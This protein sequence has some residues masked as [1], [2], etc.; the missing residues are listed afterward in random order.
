M[1]FPGKT[2]G[3]ISFLFAMA[4]G[5]YTDNQIGAIVGLIDSAVSRRTGITRKKALEGDFAR[6]VEAIKSLIK[7]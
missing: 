2:T 3:R 1:S 5:S 7:P 4:A 6:Q